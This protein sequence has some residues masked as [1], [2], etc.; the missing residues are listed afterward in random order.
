MSKISPQK[1]RLKNGKWIVIRSVVKKDAKPLLEYVNQIGGESDFLTF[2]GGEFKK[3]KTEEE[4]IIQ[5]HLRAKNAV[6]IVAEMNKEIVGNL[7][8]SSKNKKRIEHVADFGVS[9][10]KDYWRMGIGEILIK[11]MVEWAKSSKIIRKINLVVMVHNKAAIS[12]YKKMGFEI[13]GQ[14]RRDNFIDGKF[15]DSYMMG[16]LIK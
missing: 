9:V 6:F 1:F 15:Y 7:I 4:K 12:L 10:K 11:T 8:A 5:E 2:G 13:E 3:T 16:L 14:L